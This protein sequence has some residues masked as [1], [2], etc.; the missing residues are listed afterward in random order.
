MGDYSITFSRTSQK[1]LENLSEKAVNRIFPKI[2]LLK[3]QPRPQGSNKLVG[4]ANLFRIRIDPY[5]VI[6]SIDDNRQVVDIIRVR[7]RKDVYR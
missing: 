3:Q 7:H 2:A 6:Y 5:R 4:E 1:E